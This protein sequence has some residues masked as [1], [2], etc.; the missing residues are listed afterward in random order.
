MKQTVKK[1]WVERR[2]TVD[3]WYYTKNTL[4]V[5]SWLIFLFALVMSYYAAPETN[6]G[7]VRYYDLEIRQFWLTPLTG[8]LYILLWLSA[9]GSYLSMIIGKYRS[10]RKV[11]NAEYNLV[12]LLSVNLIWLMYLLYQIHLVQ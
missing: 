12:F 6:Y 11:D 8:Y 2:K 3:G 10:R 5:V 4:A 1:K 7:V 9:L